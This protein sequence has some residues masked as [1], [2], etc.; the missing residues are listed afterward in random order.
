MRI[1]KHLYPIPSSSGRSTIRTTALRCVA[2]GR[3]LD[4]NAMLNARNA[5]YLLRYAS[6]VTPESILFHSITIIYLRHGAGE[7][8]KS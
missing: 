4:P 1:A 8:A 2:P 3:A 7:A 6:L 5:M